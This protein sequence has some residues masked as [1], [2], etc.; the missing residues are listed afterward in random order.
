MSKLTI[1][2]RQ[3][4]IA[5]DF[6][7][8]TI[9]LSGTLDDSTARILEGEISAVVAKKPQRIVLEIGALIHIKGKALE[10][11]HNAYLAQ[12]THAGELVISNRSETP[13]SIRVESTNHNGVQIVKVTGHLDIR[14]VSNIEARFLE[15]FDT[16]KAKVLVDFSATDSL[17]SLGIRML[18]QGIKSAIAHGGRT[19][20]LN[21]TPPIASALE[22]AGFGHFIARGNESEIAAGL[23]GL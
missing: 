16:Q 19:L 8:A 11:L 1:A 2:S 14:G 10:C 6:S 23:R 5:D 4:T 20:V 12:L 21:P 15:N 18:A 17:S 3:K 7:E 22:T 9:S 13:E